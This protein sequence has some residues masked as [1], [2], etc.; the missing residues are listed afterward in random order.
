MEKKILLMRHAEAVSAAV[1]PDR[2]LSEHGRHQA[3]KMAAWMQAIRIPVKIILHSS[4]HRSEETAQIVGKK[5]GI[6]PTLLPAL[7]P[8]E[9]I[10]SLAQ[11]IGECASQTLLVGHLPNLDLLSNLLLTYDE[12]CSTLSF[13][14]AAI[15]AYALSE[16]KCIMDWY[17][18][19]DLISEK[20]IMI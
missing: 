14:P 11:Y 5:L 13:L 8:D 3:A 19:P 10:L 17:L 16:N 6:T 7:N 12:G 20:A 1:H 18:S 9:S 4:V 2:P 15:A